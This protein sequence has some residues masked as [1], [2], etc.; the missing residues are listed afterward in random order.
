MRDG[1]LL[2]KVD[3]YVQ[4]QLEDGTVVGFVGPFHDQHAFP[5]HWQQRDLEATPGMTTF[6]TEDVEGLVEFLLGI[7]DTTQH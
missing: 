5:S 6:K 4:V 1:D 7:S 3:G 2:R